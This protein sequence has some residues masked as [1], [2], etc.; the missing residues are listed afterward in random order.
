M[1]MYIMIK[2]L[3]A[4]LL[5]CSMPCRHSCL[6]ITS[7]TRLESCYPEFG[8]KCD[9]QTSDELSDNRI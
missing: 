4:S 1:V 5:Q 3:V 2:T 8:S 7:G 9:H 6:D